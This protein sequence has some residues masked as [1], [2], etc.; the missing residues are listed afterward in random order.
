MK[1]VLQIL[2]IVVSLFLLTFL[3][4][5]FLHLF[6]FRII[7]LIFLFAYRKID[8]RYMLAVT[9]VMSLIMDVT[10]HYKLGTNLLLF[11]IPLGVFSLFTL[12]SSVEDGVGAYVVRFFSIFL[13]YILN[14]IL[15]SFLLTGS[16]GSING[17]SVLFSFI[18]ALLSI[19]LLLL[20]N[21][22]IGG[23]RKRGGRAQIRLK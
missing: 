5:F 17:R 12:F 20:I 18:N 22:M 16:L 13:Y 11:M 15:P 3:E 10:M 8:W 21:Y 1:T 19:L 2:Y 7:F 4:A 6:A 23:I 9:F 14:L